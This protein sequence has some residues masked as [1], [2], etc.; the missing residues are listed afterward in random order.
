[1]AEVPVL[2]MRPDGSGASAD[3]VAAPLL[4]LKL[5]ITGCATE[6]EMNANVT[7]TI[8]R[9]YVRFNESLDSRLGERVHI[10]GSGPSLR[11]TWKEIPAGDHIL[12]INSAIGYLIE[13]GRPPTWGMIWDAADICEKFAVPHPDVTYLIGAR[14]HPKVFERLAGC[15]VIVWHAGGDHNIHKYLS[16]RNIQEPL[17]NGG[18]AGV[19]R[20]L[21]LGYAIGYRD[22]YL[23]GADSSYSAEGDTHIRGSLVPEKDMQIFVGGRWF[24]TTPEWCAQVE[25]IKLIYPIFRMPSMQANISC[26]GDGMFQHVVKIMKSDEKTALEVARATLEQQMNHARQAPQPLEGAPA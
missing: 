15:K 26:Y 11:E 12:A 10:C 4:P 25:E 1:M 22:F 9:G 5:Y 8:E 23:H 13:Q 16:E 14:C 21:Y 24:R 20:S 18:T 17:V 2:G 6:Q 3:P 7:A 19:T